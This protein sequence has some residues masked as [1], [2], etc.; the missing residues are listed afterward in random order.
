MIVRDLGLGVMDAYGDAGVIDT[1]LL[2]AKLAELQGAYQATMSTFGVPAGTWLPALSLA[3]I[4]DLLPYGAGDGRQASALQTVAT[5]LNLLS[6]DLYDAVI[7]NHVFPLD[8]GAAANPPAALASWN[9]LA[10]DIQDSLTGVLN[11]QG[12]WGPLPGIKY[13]AGQGLNPLNW[14]WYLQLAAGL[15]IYTYVRPLLGL[16]PGRSK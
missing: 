6:T 5:S 11:Y 10:A 4:Q 15:A 9:Q 13:L 12:K 16:L 14:P 1:A 8:N 3:Q 7:G 2:D